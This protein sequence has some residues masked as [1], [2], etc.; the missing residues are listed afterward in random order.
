MRYFLR[1][2]AFAVVVERGHLA[3]PPTDRSPIG[4]LSLLRDVIPAHVLMYIVEQRYVDPDEYDLEE[5]GSSL[6]AMHSLVIESMAKY[7]TPS[8]V[9]MT[10]LDRPPELRWIPQCQ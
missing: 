7:G 6:E 3:S 2:N 1:T 8:V 4:L 9:T 10:Y 5:L